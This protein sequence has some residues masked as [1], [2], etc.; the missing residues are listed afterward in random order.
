MRRS[1][2]WL[3][4]ALAAITSPVANAQDFPTRPVTWVLPFAAGGSTD[5]IARV[6]AER[7]APTLGQPVL[8]ENK[9]GATGAI[10]SEHVARAAPDGHT[11]LMATIST[12]SVL[13]TLRP[14][15][16]YDAARDFAPVTLVARAPNVLIV[17]PKVPAR[18]VTELVAWLKAHPDTSTF[19]S[20]GTGG[21]THLVGELFNQTAGV[22]VPHVPYK[23]GVQAVPDV[24]EGRV[25][26]IF[27]SIVWS[28]PQIRAGKLNGL[29]ITSAERSPLAPDLPTVA[30]SGMPG[31]EGVT[32]FGVVAPARTPPAVVERL[33]REI[34]RVLASP[35]VKEKLASLGAEASPTTPQAFAEIIRADREKWARVIRAANLKID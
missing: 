28:L 22:K 34:G 32:W 8:V 19:A 23:T 6:V 3:A 4:L 20:S 24:M 11:I 16:P 35:D 2:A 5:T 26:Y 10:A 17:S 31:F 7:L 15:L 27:D 1:I 25:Q 18:N 14:T 9:P 12:H 13:P 21:I 29:A 33:S 30:E